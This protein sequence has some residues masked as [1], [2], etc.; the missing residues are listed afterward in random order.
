MKSI[1]VIIY[2]KNKSHYNETF[3]SEFEIDQ[4]F[5]D[6]KDIIARHSL[7]PQRV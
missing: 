1:N 4:Y 7:K 5:E 2:L 6:S 3:N